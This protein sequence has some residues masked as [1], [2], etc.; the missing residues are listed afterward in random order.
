MRAVYVEF[1]QHIC[2]LIAVYEIRIFESKC[3]IKTKRERGAP[4]WGVEMRLIV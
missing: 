2:D 3:L 1:E 4:Y